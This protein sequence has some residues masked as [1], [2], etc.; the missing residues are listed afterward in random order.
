MKNDKY[1]I[2]MKEIIDLIRNDCL[3]GNMGIEK[4]Q[5]SGQNVAE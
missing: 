5:I 1:T 3:D 2:R 4:V